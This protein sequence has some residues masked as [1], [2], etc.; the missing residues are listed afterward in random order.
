MIAK[1]I[2]R[3]VTPFQ[4]YDAEKGAC[5]PTLHETLEFVAVSEKPYNLDG[6][7]EDNSFARWTPSAELK[8]TVTNPNLFGTLK[9]GEKYY[10]TFEKA[11]E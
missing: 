7:S 3:N 8:M 1:F 9:V 5:G 6:E 2:V 10:L 11:K 4:H